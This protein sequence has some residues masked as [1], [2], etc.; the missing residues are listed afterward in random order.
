VNRQPLSPPVDIRQALR[1]AAD[2]PELLTDLGDE[3]RKQVPDRLAELRRA[4][5]GGDAD[6]VWRVAHSLKGALASL[7][8]VTAC[9]QAFELEELGR[10]GRLDAARERLD[11]L[12]R[13]LG[14]VSEFLAVPRWSHHA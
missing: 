11:G 7:A 5:E 14:R 10:A 4:L 9:Q 12:E 6:S 8:A 13:E 3:F 2:D 1:L